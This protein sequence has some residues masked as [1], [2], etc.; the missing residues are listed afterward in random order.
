MNKISGFHSL[1]KYTLLC[2]KCPM[3][4]LISSGRQLHTLGNTLL[5]A[6]VSNPL[7]L[8]STVKLCIPIYFF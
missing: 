8:V 7:P 4:N 6:L 3:P 5:I 1:H 2:S